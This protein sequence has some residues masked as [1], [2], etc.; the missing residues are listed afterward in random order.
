MGRKVL[1][2]ARIAGI[3]LISLEL[4]Y[5]LVGN[6]AL[7]MGVVGKALSG[8][9]DAMLVTHGRAYTLLP[10]R[11]HVSDFSM[12]LQDRNIQFLLTVASARVDMDPFALLRRTFRG[13]HV[14]C[15]GVRFRFVN[16]VHDSVGMEARLA[17]YPTI[18]GFARPALFQVPAPPMATK[19]DIDAQWTVR[20]DDVEGS[21]SELW[22]LEHRWEGTGRVTGRFE[23][24]PM[25]RLRVGP[26]EL[27]LDGGELRAGPHVVSKDLRL[28]VGATVESF[29]VQALADMQVFRPISATVELEAKNFSPGLLALYVPGLSARGAGSLVADVRVESGRFGSGTRVDL[30]MSSARAEVEGFVYNGAPHLTASYDTAGKDNPGKLRVH[31]MVPGSVVV[32]VSHGS[33]AR[34]DITGLLMDLTLSGHDIAESIALEKLTVRLEEARVLDAR[35]IGSAAATNPLFFFIPPLLGDGPLVASGGAVEKTK[36]V[37]IAR[38]RHARLGLAEIR[39][40]ARTSKGGW[41]GAASGHVG[42]MP[43]GVRLKR[44]KTEVKLFVSDD[45]LDAEL[46]A[47]GIRFEA[48]VAAR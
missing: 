46:A 42:F 11:V 12:R 9:P 25:R 22:F 7:S 48:P 16:R 30:R 40:A 17:A 32:P 28:R 34:I 15:E 21:V 4:V 13:D 44:G 5:L 18:P 45:W 27:T 14:R 33:T 38:L 10:G 2:I 39:G 20:L 24:S 6:L 31:A 1:G 41:D 26:A 3:A 29:D 8:N 19:E 23:L 37:T 36:D 43:I 35:T 47:A